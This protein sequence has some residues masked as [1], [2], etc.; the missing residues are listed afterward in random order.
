[1]NHKIIEI[2]FKEIP[3]E[4][5]KDKKFFF[6]LNCDFRI[7]LKQNDELKNKDNIELRINDKEIGCYDF[8]CFE[9]LIQNIS[10]SLDQIIEEKRNPSIDFNFKIENNFYNSKLDFNLV[11]D[12]ENQDFVLIQNANTTIIDHETNQ[13]FEDSLNDYLVSSDEISQIPL[14]TNFFEKNLFQEFYQFSYF[15]YPDMFI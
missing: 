13:I 1:L 14:F 6:N 3:E 7:T 4:L 2:E 10:S 9:K 5:V 12:H 11:Y 8:N 15:S